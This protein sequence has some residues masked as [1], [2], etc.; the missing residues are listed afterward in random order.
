VRGKIEW[1]AIRL[2][3]HDSAGRDTLGG[4]MHKDFAD[5]LARY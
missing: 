3:L 1:T 5:T 2:D 4:A